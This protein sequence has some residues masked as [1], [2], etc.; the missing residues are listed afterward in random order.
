[1]MSERIGNLTD[2]SCCAAA[3]TEIG[4]CGGFRSTGT[5]YCDSRRMREWAR[6]LTLSSADADRL[7]QINQLLL[8]PLD[9]PSK[10]WDRAVADSL[11][12]FLGADKVAMIYPCGGG[13]R[14]VNQGVDPVALT[15][16]FSR[17]RKLHEGES[18]LRELNLEVWNCAMLDHLAQVRRTEFYHDFIVPFRLFDALAMAVEPRQ[19]VEYPRIAFFHDSEHT[20]RFGRRGLTILRLL[21]PAFKAGIRIHA[22]YAAG[23]SELAA[24]LDTL[25]E[26]L[27]VSDTAG[28]PL[29]AN[30]ALMRLLSA[31]REGERLRREAQ[32][33]AHQLGAY[34]SAESLR[35]GLHR[36]GERTVRTASAT[37]RLRGS[38]I[39]DHVLT[40]QQ[41]VLVALEPVAPELP[42]ALRL[43]EYFRLTPREATVARLLAL[44]RSNA[45]IATELG[46]TERTARAHTEMV[47][48]KLG[49]HSRAQVG[50]RLA[51]W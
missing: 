46:T 11:G 16:Y 9:T 1:M 35:R 50:P 42:S 21:L 20:K 41:A 2:T 13:L 26:G 38:V 4:T 17:Y 24:A 34:P 49:V 22:R 48:L 43:R 12:Q 39:A 8:A 6:R 30:A 36:C 5:R 25:S 3:T 40:P 29:H 18:H 7:H 19:S 15:L 10:T 45:A 33:L 23:S 27:I 37:Y 14:I 32:E 47:L 44:G 28:R 31:D 51:S